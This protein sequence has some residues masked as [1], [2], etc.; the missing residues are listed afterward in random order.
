MAYC[1]LTP[2]RYIFSILVRCFGVIEPD[3]TFFYRVADDT[4]GLGGQFTGVVNLPNTGFRR[5]AVWEYFLVFYF[6]NDLSPTHIFAK[7]AKMY[8]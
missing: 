5:K 1:C 3:Q 7:T 8:R 4:R 6:L 2:E